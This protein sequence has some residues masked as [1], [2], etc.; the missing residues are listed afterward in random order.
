MANVVPIIVESRRPKRHKNVFPTHWSNRK[1]TSGP[2]GLSTES[3]RRR[4]HP[5][6]WACCKASYCLDSGSK[7]ALRSSVS[8]L[9]G[10]SCRDYPIPTEPPI[11][12]SRRRAGVMGTIQENINTRSTE[13]EHEVSLTSLQSSAA[14]RRFPC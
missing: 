12:P 1:S 8:R 2:S 4:R 6:A 11:G 14:L 9:L 5:P 7:E 3:A 13:L 10:F